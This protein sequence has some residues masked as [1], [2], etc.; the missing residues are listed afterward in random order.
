MTKQIS[1]IIWGNVALKPEASPTHEGHRCAAA[2]TPTAST[3]GPADASASVAKSV[4]DVVDIISKVVTTGALIVGGIWT[5]A[6]FVENREVY[7]R[8]NLK[9][10][11][12]LVDIDNQRCLLRLDVTIEN[13]GNVI[14]QL[15]S[16]E[17]RVESIL[18]LSRRI[19]KSL[20]IRKNP[21]EEGP[22]FFSWPVIR[23]RRSSWESGE[24][25]LEPNEK[26]TIRYEFI[27][28]RRYQVVNVFT[29]FDNPTKNQNQRRIGWNHSTLID[30]RDRRCRSEEKAP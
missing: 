13:T 5:Y 30:L 9:H 21:L 15:F 16:G 3:A 25:E 1:G 24:F 12:T 18:P 26:D 14:L 8:A 7:A 10:D 19:E 6:L 11:F 29:H 22:A 2:E 17:V 27:I 4:H 23:L 20:E 28:S